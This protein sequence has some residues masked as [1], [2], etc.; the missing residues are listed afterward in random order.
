MPPSK[1]SESQSAARARV[2]KGVVISDDEEE[3]DAPKPARAK[4]AYKAKAKAAPPDPDA[5]K[6]VRAMMDIDDGTRFSS[7]KKADV[8]SLLPAHLLRSRHKDLSRGHALRVCHF[9]ACQRC[10]HGRTRTRTRGAY[11]SP[12]EEAEE[13]GARGSQRAQ[14]ET[15]GQIAHDYGRQGLLWCVLNVF[16]I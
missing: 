7:T 11:A 10:R 2:K 16:C 5:E 8:H 4:A 15:G 12:Y 14:E 1:R 6:E 13:S 3:V 9:A